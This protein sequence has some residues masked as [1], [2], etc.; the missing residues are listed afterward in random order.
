MEKQELKTARERRACGALGLSGRQFGAECIRAGAICVFGLLLSLR[1]MLFSTYPLAFALLASSVRGTPFALLGVVIGSLV[2]SEIAPERILGAAICTIARIFSG[3][4]LGGGSGERK[5]RAR[6]ADDPIRFIVSF[7]SEHRYL[8]MMSGAIGA[9]AT[10]IWQIIRGGFRFYDLFGAVFSLILVPSATWVFS[11]YFDSDER[12]RV[13]GTSFSE[14][15]SAARLRGLSSLFLRCAVIYSLGGATVLGISVPIL[16]ALILTLR[17]CKRSLLHGV[18]EG[19][20]LG[21]AYSPTYAPMLAFCALAYASISRLSRFGGGIAASIAGLIWGLYIGGISNLGVLLPTLLGG[22]M[23]YCAADRMGV[24]EDVE[25][26]FDYSTVR[27]RSELS[28]AAPLEGLLAERRSVERDERLRAV[29]ESFSSL[30]EIFY[31]LSTRLKRPSM[32]DLRT[33]CE[34]SFEHVCEGCENREICFGAEYGATLEIM[35]KMTVRLHDSGIVDEKKLPSAFKLRCP[36]SEELVCEVNRGC[37]VATKRAFQNEKTEVFALDYDA[38][39]RILNDAIAENGEEFRTDPQMARRVSQAI[40][41]EGYGEHSAVVYGRRKLSILARGLELSDGGADVGR[42]RRR[43]EQ[44]VGVSLNDPTFELSCGS[45]NMQL[46]ARRSFSAETAFCV[47]ASEGESVCGDTVSIFENQNDYLYALISDGMGRGRRAAL[48]SEL[49]GAFLRNMLGAG[50]RMEASL[51]MLNSVL[52]A[53][54]SQSED[55][56]SATV[57]LM[58]LDL[59]SGAMS[60]V[61]SGAAP[62]LLV[63]RGNVFKLASPSLPI[64]ILQALDAKQIDISCEDGDLLVMVSDGA[65]REGDD[66][67][68]LIELLRRGDLADEPPTTIADRIMKQARVEAQGADD[69]SVVVVRVKREK[70]EW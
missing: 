24:F 17:A 22:A 33:I 58:Q 18:V 12:R 54:S 7:F 13:L 67:E 64:G 23:T 60:L 62:T 26:L 25:E 46:G 29:S 50:N 57:D 68:Y 65:A 45:V 5:A 49:S 2:G 1:E 61:K 6:F 40:A 10:A 59:Y 14:T 63:R 31:N 39:S 19:L 51:R 30:S 56:C 55:E 53:R 28:D 9:F 38:I 20:L 47:L 70:R 43:L 32:L 35:K 34:E 11:W 21:L 66:Y 37:A 48:A 15:P 69:V 36:A 42:L 8:R 41:E 52:C 4:L 44:V 3:R 27:T 16:A